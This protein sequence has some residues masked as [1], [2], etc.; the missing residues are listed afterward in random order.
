MNEQTKTN[1]TNETNEIIRIE[2][3]NKSFGDVQVFKEV[4]LTVE[5]GEAVSLI[6]PS[7]CGKSTLLRCINRL[8]T[9]SGGSIRI[10]GR[11][12]VRGGKY[13][14]E[15]EARAVCSKTA[16]CFQQFNLFPH[17][18]VMENLTEAPVTVQGRKLDEVM[19]EARE[20][21]KKV[22]L[23]TKADCYPYE[24]SGGQQQRVA[25]ARALAI[26]PEI[27]LFDEPTSALDPEL[28]QEVIQVIKELA[29]EKMTMLVST[30]KMGFA[31]NFASKAVFL[32]DGGIVEQGAPE[33]I[34]SAPETERLKHFL[35][36]ANR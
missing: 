7:G 19:P 18:T 2:K 34:F 21:L 28:T 1:E 27:M 13:V 17:M 11:W 35:S 20:L 23:E 10:A 24:L 15:E 14:P 6:G 5:K 4:N 31:R 12:L 26:R 3:L 16:M 9:V 36:A 25:I 33:K 32:A 22:G 30:H 8:E 29:E